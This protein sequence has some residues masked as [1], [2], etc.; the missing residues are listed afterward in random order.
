[1]INSELLY[2]SGGQRAYL[3]FQAEEVYEIL[4]NGEPIPKDSNDY[5]CDIDEATGKIWSI[6]IF[7]YDYDAVYSVKYK[8][9]SGS[10]IVNFEDKVTASIES[11]YGQNKNYIKLK[12]EPFIDKTIDYCSVKFTDTSHTGSGEEI[13]VENVTD[14]TNQSTSYKNFDYSS[15]K[16]QFYV[17]KDTIYFNKPIEERFLIDISY[18][19]LISKIKLKAI[20]RRNT[21]K[22][23]WLTPILKEIKYDIET[24]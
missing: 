22:D 17:N 23:G 21:S 9:V 10:D 6:Q 2:I 15:N 19:H 16:Y 12:N 20:L 18:R 5:N 24:F 7:N 11:T 14:L 13:E 8:P 3:R 4:K 1:M